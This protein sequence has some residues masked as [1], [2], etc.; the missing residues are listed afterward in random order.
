M[1]TDESNIIQ[2]YQ[3]M[4]KVFKDLS[5]PF[6]KNFN[7]ISTKPSLPVYQPSRKLLLIGLKRTKMAIM[8][9][10]LYKSI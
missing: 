10:W 9:S 2:W 8:T 6:E 4:M 1:E 5:N 3:T 7:N